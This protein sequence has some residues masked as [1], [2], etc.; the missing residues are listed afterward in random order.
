M[1]TSYSDQFFV[2]DPYSPP[3]AGTAMNFVNYTLIDQDDDLDFEAAG[4]DTVNGSDIT[5]SWPGD[6]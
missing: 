6:R 3:P 2:I 5:N 1:P 4:G